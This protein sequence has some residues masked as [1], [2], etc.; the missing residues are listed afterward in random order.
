[1]SVCVLGMVLV[2]AFD[3]L[4]NV[5][6]CVLRVVLVSALVNLDLLTYFLL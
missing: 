4:K 2:S 3:N 5:R 1:M 6:V